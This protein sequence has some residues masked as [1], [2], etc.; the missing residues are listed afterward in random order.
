MSI[1]MRRAWSC[2]GSHTRRN[3]N[4]F[5]PVM[6][7]DTFTDYVF[8]IWTSVATL[9]IWIWIPEL[10]SLLSWLCWYLDTLWRRLLSS[11]SV[12]LSGSYWRF[13]SHLDSTF[14]SI[15][16][17]FWIHVKFAF[18]HWLI[19]V[20]EKFWIFLLFWDQKGKSHAIASPL[21]HLALSS[22][23]CRMSVSKHTDPSSTGV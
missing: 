20:A 3:C 7:L 22:R 9:K 13:G 4:L 17:L 18:F 12:P 14:V 6:S 1:L 5:V 11:V 10:S 2:A 16:L 21:S 19:L 23:G 15:H 8:N